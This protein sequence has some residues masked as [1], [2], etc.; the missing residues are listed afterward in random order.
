MYID[1]YKK[2]GELFRFMIEFLYQIWKLDEIGW[3][4]I[5]IN[6]VVINFRN[7]MDLILITLLMIV[8]SCYIIGCYNPKIQ[9]I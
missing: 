9:P 8:G 5:L 2:N 3:N 7:W 1:R 6:S 4:F